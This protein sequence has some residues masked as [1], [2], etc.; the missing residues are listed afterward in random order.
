MV[1]NR[2]WK[3]I[4]FTLIGILTLIMLGIQGFQY[5]SNYIYNM[6][7]QMLVMEEIAE[8]GL[9][10]LDELI[11][12]GQDFPIMKDTGA[13]ETEY[14]YQPVWVFEIGK[15]NQ[16]SLIQKSS[17]KGYTDAEAMEMAQEIVS[18]NK[19]RGT[20]K[21]FWY[22]IKDHI[23]VMI[24][25][26]E[27]FRYYESQAVIFLVTGFMGFL[28]ITGCSLLVARWLVKP[29]E[30]AFQ[31]QKQFVSD[32]SHELKT[33]LAVIG[34]NAQKLQ[35]EI[36]ENK[37]LNYILSENKRMGGL[38]KEL[39]TLA[40]AEDEA[41][42][43]NFETV[44]LSKI[45]T[46]ALLPYESL[47]YENQIDYWIDIQEGVYIQGEEEH[48]KQAVIVLADNAFN[49]VQEH[50]EIRAK[51]LTKGKHIEISVSNTGQEIPKEEQKKIF[52]RFYR[53]DKGRS[54]SENRYG[55]GLAIASGI[56]ERH[57]GRIEV[58]SENGRTTFTILL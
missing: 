22:L 39:L 6:E 5:V 32:A 13:D 54:R 14:W 37:W 10:S 44:N 52:T 38:L 25:D 4:A 51:L 18:L 1:V 58:V 43:H 31:Q 46:R 12:D 8:R 27:T 17:R 9:Y 21:R 48:L 24:D 53:V 30:R 34:A 29:A 55:L 20:Y 35:S 50:G 15:E 47:A 11:T 33:P 23:M 28:L 40:K 7:Y 57:K 42:S 19:E 26:K 45:V 2:L 49:H 56:A 41:A 36:G 16:L 3:R